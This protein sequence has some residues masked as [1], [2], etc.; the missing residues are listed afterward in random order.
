MT[1]ATCL[2]ARSISFR[3]PA[4][5]MRSP[6]LLHNLDLAIGEGEF[7]GI[8][9]ANGAGKTTLLRLLTGSLVP[10]SGSVHLFGRPAGSLAP[11][12]RARLMASVPQES[13]PAFDFT[14]IQ[15]VLMGRT[16]YL[17]LLGFEGPKDIAIAEEALDFTDALP[18]ASRQFG[19]L[20]AGEKQRVLLARALAQQAKVILLDEP[21]AWLDLGHQLQIYELLARLER[22]RGLTV[23]AVSHDLN[24]AGRHCGRLIL[25]RCGEI[26]VQG[27]PREVLTEAAIRSAY[28]VEARVV[29]DPVLGP[30]VHPLSVSIPASRITRP[31]PRA[32][33]PEV[34]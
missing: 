7:V 25:M 14:A 34:P 12:E 32:G 4:G 15:L 22:E 30:L 19:T 23:V 17:G 33:F 29:H 11:A 28:G 24:L 10:T 31:A 5:G 8:L 27:P 1:T 26:L 2:E 16:P 20:S 3:Y 6:E 21:T 13:R 18:F 9:G